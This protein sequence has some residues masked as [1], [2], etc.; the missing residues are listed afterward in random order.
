MPACQPIILAP[1]PQG[2][3]RQNRTSLREH[4]GYREYSKT[5]FRARF[6]VFAIDGYFDLTLLEV[7]FL[8]AFGDWE[9]TVS[10]KFDLCTG[11]ALLSLMLFIFEGSIP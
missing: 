5:R 8:D 7:L 9:P 6:D 1:V 3:V 2:K 4:D 10:G 11:V